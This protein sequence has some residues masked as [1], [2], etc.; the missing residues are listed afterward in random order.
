MAREQGIGLCLSGGG[1]RAMVYHVG[2]I[3]RLHELG[4]LSR[5]DRISSVSGGSITAG[6]L[7]LLPPWEW[8]PSFA[9]ALDT[10]HAGR[11]PWLLDSSGF[12]GTRF[13]LPS[14]EGGGRDPGR[15]D[16]GL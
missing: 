16:R 5:I 15:G 6:V 1:Y 2:A 10:A 12:L 14:R 4:L 3:I 7:A 9:A 11:E 8:W 13:G